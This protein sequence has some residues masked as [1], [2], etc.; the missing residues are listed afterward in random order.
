METRRCDICRGVIPEGRLKVLPNTRHCVQ[1]SDT[2]KVAGFRVIS[3][4]HTY[5]EMQIV[6]QEK[7]KE[8][9]RKQARSGQA[10][11]RGVLMGG[12]KSRKIDLGNIKP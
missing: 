7:F 9:S 6:S 11:G 10:P 5:T 12:F 1:C 4:K 8:L 2:E 3:G